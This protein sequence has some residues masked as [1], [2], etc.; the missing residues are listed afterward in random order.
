MAKRQMFVGAVIMILI[1]I[2]IVVVPRHGS[3]PTA[4]AAHIDSNEIAATPKEVPTVANASAATIKSPPVAKLWTRPSAKIAARNLRRNRLAVTLRPLGAGEKLITR[5]ADGDISGVVMELKQ[6]AQRGDPSASNLLDYMAHYTCA[7]AGGEGEDSEAD[8]LDAQ[9]LP[10]ADAEWVGI[11]IQERNADN[12]QWS[13]V[14]QQTLDK[15]EANRWV[16]ASAAQGDASSLYLLSLFGHKS[17]NEQLLEAA[18]GGYPWAEFTLASRIIGGGNPIESGRTDSTQNAGDLL[19]AAAADLPAAEGQLALCE[20]NGCPGIEPDISS[21]VTHAREAAQRGSYDAMLE[22]GPQLQASQIDPDEV[23]AW[24][25][26]YA[27][28]E[29]LG[30]AG[31]TISVRLM[32]SVSYTL[33]SPAIATNAR[34]LAEKYWQDYGSQI[35]SNLGCG[36]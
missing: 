23:A 24:N 11:A 34:T 18:A 25:L 27:S 13:T 5:L 7:L 30:C 21:A 28:L 2:G 15:V 10:A 9:A 22:I 20:F 19:R 17:R 8:S 26:V 4:P 16:E 1:V 31:Q 14:C 29:Q 32:K 12:K 6:Q 35:L 36:S 3:A 33:H